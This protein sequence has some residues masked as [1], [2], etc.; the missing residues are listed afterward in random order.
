MRIGTW[1]NP[2]GFTCDPVIGS[3][4]TQ[5]HITLLKPALT[6]Q[7]L[8]GAGEMWQ[9]C[10]KTDSDFLSIPWP[11]TVLVSREDAIRSAIQHDDGYR[12]GKIW[13]SRDGGKTW[14]WE[15]KT[16]AEFDA[17]L[18]AGM[19]AEAPKPGKAGRWAIWTWPAKC[20]IVYAGIRA[21]GWYRWDKYR[22]AETEKG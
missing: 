9:N 3:N 16:R 15:A 17:A 2:D 10:R 8:D 1:L 19:R 14:C 6:F 7:F 21:G 22:R 5:W 11:G 4:P 18:Y 13:V 20:R 12:H